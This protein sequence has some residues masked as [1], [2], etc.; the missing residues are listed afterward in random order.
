MNPAR[1]LVRW[2]LLLAILTVWFLASVALVSTFV[3]R[4][5]SANLR[6]HSAELVQQSD[7]V[8]YHFERSIASLYGVPAT[9]ADDPEV[10]AVLER[11]PRTAYR[12]E[13]PLPAKRVALA[14]VP[15]LTILNSHLGTVCQELGVD[16]VWVVDAKGDCIASSNAGRPDSFLGINYSDRTYFK[17][18]MAG[19]RGRQYAVGRATNIPGFFFSAPISLNGT[20]AGAVVAKIDVSRLAQWFKRLDC[21][22]ADELGAVI[23]SSDPSM[24][25]SA[26]DGS[27]LFR[28]APE[29]LDRIYKRREFTA[30]TIGDPDPRFL[31]HRSLVLPN[32]RTPTMVSSRFRPEDGYTIYSFRKVPEA[33]ESR[34]VVAGLVTLVFTAGAALILL[35][36]GVRHH[37]VHL[38]QAI[39]AAEAA[40]RSKSEFLATMSHEIRTPMNGIIGL[41]RLMMDTSLDQEQRS[42]LGSL[43]ASA[44]NLLTIINDIL[45]FSKIEAG[46]I[47]FE[48]I[49]F[50]VRERLE[51][52][53]F[54]F[55]MKAEESGVHLALEIEDPVPGIL[56]GDPVRLCQV[57]NN[58]VGNAIKFTPKGRVALKCALPSTQG[59]RAFLRFAVEDTGI[60]IPKEEISRI[61]EK[62][63]QADSSTTRL[64]GGTGLGLAISRRLTE[65]MGGELQVESIEGVGST[66]SVVLPFLLAGPEHRPRPLTPA[67]PPRSSRALNILV[68]DDMPINQLVAQKTIAQTGNHSIDCAGNG[69][70]AIGKWSQNEFDLIFMDVQM[71]FMDGLE[72][73]RI[74]RSREDGSRRR[75]HICAMTAN[76]MKED[77]SICEA[78]GMDSYISKPLSGEDV[79]GLIHRFTGP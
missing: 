45:D 50:A 57:L 40:S 6:R 47:E 19:R 4:R 79:H 67:A 27:R 22:I 52:A 49:P 51:A 62:F 7:A 65:L 16:I 20:P 54:P 26:I 3:S 15:G 33:A 8:S 43:K 13:D 37:L 53:L 11:I 9:I 21:F 35:V 73:T 24:E 42:Y 58:L 78:A 31:P 23:L 12:Q 44:D 77:R 10:I 59:N 46:R 68:V 72:A 69:L 74:I 30:L 1:P 36:A 2:G 75:V 28:I 29:E 66:F 41:A 5:L 25:G 76:A 38:R 71:P 48:S 34:A 17:S 14:A 39:T 55:R 18:A 63:T 32:D 70:E 56:L 61:F 64:Y 60:G